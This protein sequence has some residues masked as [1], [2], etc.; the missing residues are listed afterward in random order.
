MSAGPAGGPLSAYIRRRTEDDLY[1][2]IRALA[3]LIGLTPHRVPRGMPK[4]LPQ[5]GK[6]GL[7]FHVR[8]SRGSY[9]GWPDVPIINPYGCIMWR[10]LKMVGKTLSPAQRAVGD[11]LLAG[12]H[13]FAVWDPSHWPE[14]ITTEMREFRRRR[15]VLLAA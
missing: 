11:L 1:E 5:V 13:D 8:D 10:E 6:V 9:A 12:G 7:L 3:E 15:P 14:P 4:N 2:D